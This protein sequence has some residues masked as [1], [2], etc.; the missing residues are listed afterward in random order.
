MN[1]E[2]FLERSTSKVYAG[3][4]SRETPRLV[5]DLMTRIAETL[6]VLGWTLRSGG[7]D[8]ADTA[9]AEGAFNQESEIYLPWARFNGHT[10]GFGGPT[11]RAR[12]IAAEHHPKWQALSRSSQNLLARNTH[13][14]LGRFCEHP[15]AFVVCWTP[16][17]ATAKTTL[18]TGGTG[19]TIRV[20][21]AFGVPVFNLALDEHRNAWA[22]FAAPRKRIIRPCDI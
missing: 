13:Q 4:G 11:D 20:A 2:E 10:L 3:I 22:S 15:S 5:L 19:Q 6:N 7:A 17:G 16:D 8:G 1:I 21:N 18:K 12:E 9:F 14:I